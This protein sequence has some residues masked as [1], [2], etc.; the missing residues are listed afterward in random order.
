MFF[1]KQ[2]SQ[3]KELLDAEDIPSEDLY[4]N[5]DELDRI[6]SLLGGYRMSFLALEQVLAQK[7]DAN[8]LIDIGSGGG[9]SLAQIGAWLEKQGRD[10]HLWGIDLKPDC[11]AYSER[12]HTGKKLHF[13]CDDYRNMAKHLPRIDIIHASLFCHH[14]SNTQIVE[15]MVFA[16]EQGA[17]LII[18]DLHRHI[19]AYSSIK[20]LTALFSKSHLVRHDA[21]LSVAR[22]FRRSDWLALLAQAHAKHYTLRWR[23]AFRYE[24]IIYP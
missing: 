1:L 19:L 22:S 14:L 12:K 10:M 3:K 6:N 24:L 15:L 5:L 8:Y 2:R 11:I 9:D 17:V 23:W 18:N 16:R 4:R 20:L 13:I 21:A 7:T